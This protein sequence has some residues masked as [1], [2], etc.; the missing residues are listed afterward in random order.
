MQVNTGIDNE[1]VKTIRKNFLSLS[2][3]SGISIVVCYVESHEV[4]FAGKT[5]GSECFETFG[6]CV[7]GGRDDDV[8]FARELRRG[9]RERERESSVAWV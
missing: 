3:G 8:V 6:R 4:K 5:L 1:V 2:D 7:S 9:W